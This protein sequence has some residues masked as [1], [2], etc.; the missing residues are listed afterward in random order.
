MK[1]KVRGEGEGEV[2][3]EGNAEEEEKKE[4]E[5]EEEEEE[6]EEV[7]EKE[8]EGRKP[9]LG[10]SLPNRA[11]LIA[12]CSLPLQPKSRFQVSPISTWKVDSQ[13]S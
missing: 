4:V 1:A 11:R 9:R 13:E 12:A 7:E 6:K 5:E 3:Q 2:A 8:E 10:H